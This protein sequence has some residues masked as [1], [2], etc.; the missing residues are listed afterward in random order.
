[1]RG[2]S[3]WRGDD[4]LEFG[5]DVGDFACHGVVEWVAAWCS[6]SG[7][8]GMVGEHGDFVDE[9]IDDLGDVEGDGHPVE[10]GENDDEECEPGDDGDVAVGLGNSGWERFCGNGSWRRVLGKCAWEAGFAAFWGFGLLG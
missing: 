3:G 7:G 4:G 2:D 6:V 5:P 9:G 1:M 10:H 8:V